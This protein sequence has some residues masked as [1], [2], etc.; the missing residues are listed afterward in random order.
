MYYGK[1]SRRCAL[2]T[3]VSDPPF[4]AFGLPILS[5]EKLYNPIR[6]PSVPPTE[7]PIEFSR[8]VSSYYRN[9]SGLLRAEDIIKIPLDELMTRMQQKANPDPPID[10]LATLNRIS[11]ETYAQI[12]D[13]EGALRSHIPLLHIDRTIYSD[14]LRAALLGTDMWPRVRFELIWCAMGPSETAYAAWGLAALLK[15][16]GTKTRPTRIWT[17]DGANHFVSI[18]VQN[19]LF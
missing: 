2:L 12:A 6:D 5:L 10:E 19:A 1:L 13:T 11:P 7:A 16:L 9:E 8:W 18:E 3:Y 4:Y 17:L 14:N 15:E